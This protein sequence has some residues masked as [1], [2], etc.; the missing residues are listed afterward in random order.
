MDEDE[1]VA[2]A[3]PAPDHSDDDEDMPDYSVLASLSSKHLASN[4]VPG[5]TPAPSIPKRGEKDFEPTGFGGQTKGLE[6]SRNALFTTISLPRVHSSKSLSTATWDP[7]LQRAFVHI[8]RGQSCAHAG[9]SVRHQLSDGQNQT[10][11]E[12]F[13]EETVYLI[14]RGALD[15]RWTQSPGRAPSADDFSTCIPISVSQAYSHLIGKDGCTLPRYQ[16][17]AYLRRLGYIVQRASLVD[18]LRATAQPVTRLQR[19]LYVGF[20]LGWWRTYTRLVN[21]FY[22]LVRW[23]VRRLCTKRRGLLGIS[24]SDSYDTVFDKLQIIQSRELNP[25]LEAPNDSDNELQPFFYAWRPATRYKRTCPPPPEFRICVID[26]H[27]F[28]MLNAH[29]FDVLFSHIPLPPLES[30]ADDDKELAE[31][32]AQNRRAYGKQPSARVRPATTRNPSR[33]RSIMRRLAWLFGILRAI[34]SRLGIS[35]SKP[36]Q[37]RANVYIPLKAGRRNVVIAI[38]DQ[39]TMSLLRFGEAQF[40]SWRLAGHGVV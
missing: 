34:M 16:I 7:E 15:C 3:G 18:R 29:Q 35:L 32:R 23:C 28:P 21:L 22:H 31:I 24:G 27:M 10:Y 6:R 30:K 14:E 33:L 11:L 4:S 26:T 17:Y 12:L 8:Q 1:K 40:Q 2:R 38:V 20:L 13:P 9:V 36:K 37:A 5:D 39:G 19:K 25:V